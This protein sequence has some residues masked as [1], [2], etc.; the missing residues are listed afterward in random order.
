MKPG[1]LA[2]SPG[3]IFGKKKTE[4]IR[5]PTSNC[6]IFAVYTAITQAN[7]EMKEAKKAKA[8]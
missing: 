5:F 8:K 6:R 3:G 4:K 7:E 1:R 2:L